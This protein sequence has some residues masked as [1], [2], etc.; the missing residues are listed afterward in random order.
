MELRTLPL[1]LL[2]IS[3]IRPGQTQER[4]KAV[5]KTE[6]DTHETTARCEIP[7]DEDDWTYSWFIDGS[8]RPLSTD[9]EFN[10]I[11]DVSQKLSSVTCRG[12]RRDGL[13]S[14]ISD[15]VTLALSLPETP[16]AVLTVQP[17]PSLILRGETVTLTCDIQG[18][19]WTYRW[20]CGDD[21]DR[22]H[23]TEEKEFKITAEITQ[24]CRCNGCR[25]S[26]CSD[27]SDEV[28]L[29]VSEDR[30]I[31]GDKPRVTVKP[32]SSV[33]TGDTVTL[34]CDVSRSGRRI[35]WYKDH[36]RI[37]SG[38]DT[39]TLSNVRVSDGGEYWCGVLG[40]TQGPRVTL[41][42]RERPK[43][44]LRVQPDRRVFRGQTVTLTCDIQ[45]TDGTS[46]TY[47]WNKDRS[48]IHVS[49]SQ[50]YRISSVNESHTGHYSCSGRETGGSRYTHTSDEVTLT[51]SVPE[52]SGSPGT[53]GSPITS[54]PPG[55]SGSPGTSR[56]SGS[57]NLIIGV[58]AGLSVLFLLIVLLVLLWRCKHNKAGGSPSPSTEH[59]Q[60][61]IRTEEQKK[62]ADTVKG[63]SDVTYTEIDLKPVKGMKKKENQRK[64]GESSDT[65]YSKVNI[66]TA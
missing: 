20:R 49:Q 62:N 47:S 56:P 38:V 45:E 9:R 61:D 15:A 31:V 64:T 22:E 23:D 8:S 29:T 53:S 2:L 32:Q 44:V 58:S 36:Q 66:A 52:P 19:G 30:E 12:E 1:M 50:E 27:W 5:V 63:P 26:N 55:T 37:Q 18:E 24:E 11:S 6:S 51:L 39:V 21:D 14:E 42:V 25:G 43:A 60:R 3:N 57:R 17:E 16:K 40:E 10:F 46:W 7:G 48:Q 41:T 28:T 4:L 59:Q 35:I 65:V 54:R 13:K 33:F 34:R